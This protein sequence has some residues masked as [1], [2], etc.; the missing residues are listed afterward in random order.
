MPPVVRLLTSPK[1]T[2]PVDCVRWNPALSKSFDITSEQFP[3]RSIEEALVSKFLGVE[4]KHLERRVEQVPSVRMGAFLTSIADIISKWAVDDIRN[5][6][7]QGEETPPLYDVI[8]LNS[9]QSRDFLIDGMRFVRQGDQD[10]GTKATLRVEPRWYGLQVTTYGLKSAGTAET[11]LGEIVAHARDINFLKG[12]AFS[13]SGEFLPKT[14]ETFADLFLDSS[15]AAAITRVVSLINARGKSLENRGVLLMGP[16][17]T[18]KTLSARIVRNDAKATFIWVSSRDFHYA[19]SF[20]GF[21]QAFDIA[22]ECAPSVIVFEDVDNWLSDRTVDLLKTEMDGISRSSGVVTMMTTNYPEQLPAALID[23]P[24]RFHDVLKFDLPDAAARKKMLERWL[25][26][27]ESKDLDAA[28]VATAGYSGAHVRELARFAEIIGQQDRLP[29]AKALAA[30]LAKLKEQRDLITQTQQ[31]GSTYKMADIMTKSADAGLD[32]HRAYATLEIKSIDEDQRII[33]GVASHAETDRQG[34]LLE[35]DGALFKLPLPF[36]WQHNQLAPIGEVFAARVVN[37]GIEIQARVFDLPDA[38]PGLRARLDE[39]WVSIKSRLVRGLS[40]GW[41]PIKAK[42]IVETGGLHAL[43]WLWLELSAVTIPANESATILMVKSHDGRYTAPGDRSPVVVVKTKSLPGASG[44]SSTI[45]RGQN[46]K[47][48]SEQI[49]AFEA[50]RLSKAARMNEIMT[51]S[52]DTGST[53]DEAQ[54]EEY[55]G[56]ETEVKSLDVHLTRLRSL[57]EIQKKAAVPVAGR[58]PVEG[59]A[60]RTTEGARVISIRPTLEKGIE[61]ARYAMCLAAAKGFTPQALAIAESRY[62]D[63]ERIHFALK[64]AVAAGTTTDPNWAGALVQYQ[65]FSGDFVEF[66]RP[67]TIIGQFGQNGIPA[68]QQVPFNIMVKGQTS[69]GNG[70]WV[71]QGKPKPLSRFDF[72]TATLRWAK[73]A[74]IAVIT[75]ELA[76]FSSPTAETLVRKSLADA[77]I[78]RMDIDFIDPAKALV[79]DVSPASI[80]NGVTPV[81]SSGSDADAVREDVKQLMTRFIAANITPAS[82][83][84][85]MSATTALA[86]SLMRNALGQ[87][88]FPDISMTGGKFEGL[89]VI[90][91]EYVNLAGSPGNQIVVL[92]NANDIYIADDGQVVIDVSREASLEM[93]DAPT[94]SVGEGSPLAPHATSLVSLWQTNSI[95]IRAE[96]FVNWQRRREAAVQYLTGVNWGATGSPA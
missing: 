24:G 53:L 17:G 86:L 69:G 72:D 60:S 10:T 27:V 8:Q 14:S 6:N 96:R 55:A 61:F 94:N 20:G 12:E 93:S 4:I 63:M 50:T 80:T 58:T 47:T 38:P 52:A 82:G 78:E 90:V 33:V 34:D 41:K 9:T 62:P 7:W 70:Y 87:K 15:N 23:R 21:T 67:R 46:M 68:L 91:S 25:S 40:V 5:L 59:A 44:S 48:T 85:V 95:G 3:P 89:P 51:A 73:V 65:Q 31:R 49:S 30:A 56:L 76:R 26:G 18:G 77:I 42:R 84:F 74:N 83:V 11:L 32:M 75:E 28:V 16:P 13:L 66:L 92:V 29:P 39:A 45:E 37:D 22:R 35:P 71:G 57:E 19:G 2:G 36:L 1:S 88:E 64:A 54:S 81:V 79:A 43:Q